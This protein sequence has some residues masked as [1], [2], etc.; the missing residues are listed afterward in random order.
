MQKLEF[1][2]FPGPIVVTANCIIEPMKSYKNRLFTLNETGW[3]GCRHIRLP[4]EADQ[5][6]TAA[7]HEPGFSDEDCHHGKFPGGDKELSVGF[8]RDVILSNAD[9]VSRD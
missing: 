5:L 6:V 7:L 2:W 9:K 8:G 4:D 1:P 3:P